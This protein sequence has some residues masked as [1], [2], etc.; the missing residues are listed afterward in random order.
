MKHPMI[1]IICICHNHK[2]FVEDALQSVWALEYP[3]LELIVADDASTD[4]SQEVIQEL[5]KG[6][7]VKL[8]L[9]K[10]NIGHCKTFN[11][12]LKQ[13]NGEFII[14]LSADD[15]LLPYSVTV[16]VE[17]LIEKGEE[18]GV[19]FA[20]ALLI[21]DSGKQ[22]GEHKTASFFKSGVVPEGDVYA[23]ILAKYF[24]SPPTMIYRKRLV[25]EL[26]GYNEAL[27]YEDFDFWV[28]SSRMSNYCYLPV[29][30]VKKRIHG[31]SVSAMQYVRNSKMLTSTYEV[32][33]TAF[34]LNQNKK[35]DRALLKRLAYEAKMAFG[36]SNYTI[37]L[38]ML[39]LFV[40]VMFKIR[41]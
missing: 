32:C 4:G 3:Y 18:Y 13:A 2:K 12:A 39:F 27:T 16:G 1:T 20:D 38:K 5:I 7:E 14:D 31:D 11:Q 25:E 10:E 6:K 9:N 15:V 35:E 30:M 40:L 21:D 8:L 33:R 29:A 22:I 23:T 34:K 28:R 17:R 19:F 41:T 24:I 26:G 37:G 36:S